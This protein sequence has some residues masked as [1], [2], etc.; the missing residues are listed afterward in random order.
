MITNIANSTSTSDAIFLIGTTDYNIQVPIISIAYAIFMILFIGSL[1]LI[2][3]ESWKEL[4][5]E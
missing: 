4:S 1:I 5:D 2:R 3:I